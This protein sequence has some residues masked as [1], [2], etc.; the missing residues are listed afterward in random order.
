MFQKLVTDHG[1]ITD[2]SWMI[3]D[4]HPS[5]SGSG[6]S[7]MREIWTTGKIKPDG[8]I[9]CDDVFFQDISVAIHELGIKSPEQLLIA[10]YRN[11][12]QRISS[13]FPIIEFEYEAE[14]IALQ[15]VENVLAA[16][17]G[18]PIKPIAAGEP[19]LTDPFLDSKEELASV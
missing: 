8:L 7:L 4:L 11:K 5:M 9:I 3:G 14:P 13:Q 6:Y 10:A 15:A 18:E 2:E 16:L 1:G 12:G 19:K 17:K